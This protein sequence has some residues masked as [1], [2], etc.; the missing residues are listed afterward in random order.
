MYTKEE[1]NLII[2]SGIEEVKDS[3]KRNIVFKKQDENIHDFLIKTLTDGVYNI[4]KDKFNS[5]SYRAHILDELDKK[6]VKC[7]TC[8]SEEYPEALKN[9]Y[10]PPLVLYCKGN[11][12]LLKSDCFAVVG[13]RRSSASALA[14]CKKISSEL[15]EEFT[16]VSG[17][18]DGADSSALEGALPSGRVISVL[19]GGFDNIY[20]SSNIALAEKVAKNGLLICEYPPHMRAQKYNF[21]VRNRIIAGLSKGVL[22][23]SAGEKSGALITA[24]YALE[25]GRE[26]FAFPYFPNTASG[27]GCNS[28]IKN[29]AYLTENILDIFSVF[30]LDLKRRRNEVSLSEAE[31]AA[32]E[33]IRKKEVAFLP[34]VAEALNVPAYQLIPVL[35]SLEIK[36]LIV[37]LGGNRYS[38]V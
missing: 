28:L 12:S 9:I 24:D 26:I 14:L 15:T 31:S 5:K 37:R 34:F 18:A 20:P 19:A 32:L 3:V 7:V 22:V 4:V 17:L 2:L 8:L 13:S 21:P 1:E 6:G 10:A 38:V 25:Y 27:K 11:T 30:G 36:G 16:V 23:A 29:G 35:S 33:E